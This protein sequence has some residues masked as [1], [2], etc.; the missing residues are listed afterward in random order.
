[1]INDDSKIYK[2]FIIHLNEDDDEYK[3]FLSKLDASYD[4]EWKDY[5]FQSENLHME[6][7]EQME[8]VDVI[9]ILSGLYIKNRKLIKKQIDVAVKLRKPIIVVRPYGLENVPSALEQIANE[10]VGWNTPCIV[11]SIQETLEENDKD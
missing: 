9:I 8:L 4:F 10:V 2:L 11:D 5:A 3:L 7:E 1:M 6:F